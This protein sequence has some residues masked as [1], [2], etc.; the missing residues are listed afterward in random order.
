MSRYRFVII[1]SGW[2]AGYYIRIAKALPDVFELCNVYCRS[3]EKA[4]LLH[5]EYDVPCTISEEE[6]LLSDPD[7]VVVAVSKASGA[8][9]AM[10]WL[11]KGCTVLME[12]PAG[13]DEDTLLKL[14][15][16]ADAGQKLVVAEQYTRYPQYAALL[17][18]INKGLIGEVTCLNI[19]LAHEYHGAS[20]MKSILGI[21]PKDRF[22]VYCRTYSF[23]TVETLT[24]Y[25]KITGGRIKDKSRT[26]AIFEFENGKVAFYD[27]DSEQYR[28]PIRRNS[29]K[30]QG[31]KGEIID[32]SVYYLDE[33]NQ[34]IEGKLEIKTRTVNT[35]STNP[36]LRQFKEIEKISFAG[37]TLYEPPFG[38]CG[39]SD[40]ET[41]IACMMRETAEY[42][43][44]NASTPYPVTEAVADSDM[45]ILMRKARERGSR[46]GCT[47]AVCFINGG[48]GHDDN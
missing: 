34:P 1:G 44:G 43:R 26:I 27:F 6:C 29:Y 38:L 46:I 13:L 12:T 15:N 18:L 5:D 45:A 7:F 28:S 41:A 48:N 8:E 16:R 42:S 21:T 9:V 35:A 47:N 25:E 14:R 2:R 37:E 3:R 17:K 39:L 4:G 23:P 19:S 22:S 32:G 30:I 11:D 24:R 40:D 20:L 10:K 31:V 33:N 36:N